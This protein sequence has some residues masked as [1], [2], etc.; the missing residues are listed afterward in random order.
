MINGKRVLG[1][2]LARGGS[3][4][5]PGK[6][7]RPLRGKPLLGWT[8]DAAKQSSLLDALILSTDAEDIA[9]AGRAMGA[10][11]P[12]MRPAHLASDT[13]TSI[14][15]IA[16]AVQSL[17]EAGRR[18]DYLVLMEPTS[19]LRETADIDAAITKLDTTGAEAVVSV[20]RAESVHPAFMYFKTDNDYLQP[21]I[22]ATDRAPR[23]QDVA[24]VFFLEGT[25][26]AAQIE[27]LL[28]RKSFYHDATLGLEVPKWKSPEIDDEV[29]LLYVEAIMKHRGIGV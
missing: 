12:F 25:V 1:L 10:E 22:P 6:N 29:D 19:P 7:L 11:T 14:D 15:A 26:Y 2:I 17:V 20:A 3:K 9:A 27:S 16:H 4:G 24:P 5:L 8:V 23:R 13:A 28:R 18:F 21:V